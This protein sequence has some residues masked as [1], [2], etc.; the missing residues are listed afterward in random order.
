MSESY[1]VELRIVSQPC[2]LCVARAAVNAALEKCGF[3]APT[4]GK[5]MLAVD[6]AL[7]NIMRHGYEGRDDGPIWVKLGPVN[8]DAGQMFSVVIEDRARQVDPGELAGRDLEDVRPGGLG[9][10]IIRQ[11]MDD[12][13]YTRREGGGMRLVMTKRRA[14]G[15]NKHQ[16]SD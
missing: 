3:D 14:A 5:M 16:G 6:E 8:T 4:C 11:V 1:P 10:H 2:Y 7:S 12:V 13:Q 15:P 9:V